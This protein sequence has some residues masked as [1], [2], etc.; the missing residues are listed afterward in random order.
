MIPFVTLSRRYAAVG[1]DPIRALHKT[2]SFDSSRL[3]DSSMLLAA[4]R[5]VD[6][7]A[8]A[9]MG[10]AAGLP[11]AVVDSA[12]LNVT[13]L[14]YPKVRED[15]GFS[16]SSSFGALFCVVGL[17]LPMLATVTRVVGEKEA[18]VTSAMTSI[19]VPSICV[20]PLSRL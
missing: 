3:P 6:E 19:G 2:K 15:E 12:A 8:L 11:K 5:M 1:A 10:R 14:Q 17:T 18:H 13:L 7:A 4:Q 9:V 20:H 16:L